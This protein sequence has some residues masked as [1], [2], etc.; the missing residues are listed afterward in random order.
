MALI[1]VIQW[2]TPKLNNG[3]LEGLNS[4]FQAAKRKAL[5]RLF[6]LQQKVKAERAI[7]TNCLVRFSKICW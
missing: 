3:L 6:M 4:D 5:W 1:G 7:Y 2:F